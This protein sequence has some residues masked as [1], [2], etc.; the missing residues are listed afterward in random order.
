MSCSEPIFDDFGPSRNWGGAADKVFAAGDNIDV[1]FRKAPKFFG[2]FR[3]GG[4]KNS[5]FVAVLFEGVLLGADRAHDA[6]SI[7]KIAI[8]KD[9]D[10]HTLYFTTRYATM[11]I[12]T[13]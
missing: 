4:G 5:N 13:I 7:V 10:F 6:A 11:V 2:S 1:V 8:R 12:L 3:I 9:G